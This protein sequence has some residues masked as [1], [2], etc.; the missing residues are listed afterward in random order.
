[1]SI[2]G[3]PH[4]PGVPRCVHMLDIASTDGAVRTY[5]ARDGWA[6]GPASRGQHRQAGCLTGGL[7]WRMQHGIAQ[8]HTCD[9]AWRCTCNH[10]EIEMARPLARLFVDRVLFAR[11]SGQFRELGESAPV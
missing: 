8:N 3:M 4:G 1:M 2:H 6:G 7:A 9:W 10:V 5:R 11:D